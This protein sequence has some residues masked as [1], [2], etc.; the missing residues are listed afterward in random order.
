MND[1]FD[2]N[3]AALESKKALRV[4]E[5]VSLIKRYQK[6]YY[7]GEGEISDAEFE[8]M[9]IIWKYAPISTNEITD[10]LAKTKNWSPKTIYTMLSRLEKKGVIVHEKESRV[11]V[12]T[13]CVKKDDYLA[14]E[15]RTLADRF[16][17]GAMKQMVVSFL[18]QK[19]LTPEDLD[20]LQSI[21]DKK[22]RQ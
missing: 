21:L 1:L 20:E 9:N 14:A 13:P 2:V 19:D 16:F 3:E 11:F 6:S 10:R 17:D 22:R 5:L 12:Y 4:K 18:D 8:V 7:D 15:S